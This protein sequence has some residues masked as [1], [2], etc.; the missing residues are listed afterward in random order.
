MRE[1]T[2]LTELAVEQLCRYRRTK[3]P[4]RG[5]RFRPSFR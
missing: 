1:I 4:V 5:V 3:R 2:Y